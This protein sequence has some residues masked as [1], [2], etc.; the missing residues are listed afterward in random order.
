MAELSP[1]MR[2]FLAER[3][4]CVFATIRPDGVP[5]QTVLWYDVQGDRIMLNMGRARQKDRHL[6][7][8]PRASFCVEDETRYL[9]ITGTCTLHWED[10]EQAQADIKRLAARYEGPEQAEELARMFREEERETIYLTIEKI[11]ARGF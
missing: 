8:D 1:A 7:R 5:H 6:R 2:A 3:R 4:F 9:T 11:D 10:Q